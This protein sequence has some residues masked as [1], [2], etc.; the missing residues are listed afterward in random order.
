LNTEL[1]HLGFGNV[2]AINRVVAIVSP[3]SAPIKRMVQ[4]GKAKGMYVDMT[5]GRRT[6]AVVVLDSGHIVL[7]A[8]T[9]ETIA[10]RLKVSRAASAERSAESEPEGG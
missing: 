9:P 1:L 8:I 3:D 4:E 6:K 5:N 10:S 7:A 2:L